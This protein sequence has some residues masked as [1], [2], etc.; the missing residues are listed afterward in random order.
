MLGVD[1]DMDVTL[2]LLFQ[3]TGAA[4]E[5]QSAS[6]FKLYANTPDNNGIELSVRRS[7]ATDLAPSTVS[8]DV[9]L[10]VGYQ[11]PQPADRPLVLDLAR[12]YLL[13]AT[14]SK[15]GASVVA[16]DVD[17]KTFG[18]VPVLTGGQ[19]AGARI[20][21]ANV[22]SAINGGANWN[23]N[24][25]AVLVF[26]KQLADND[27]LSL[28]NYLHDELRQ[29]DPDY[30]QM[31]SLVQAAA[32]ATGC[33]YDPPTCATCAPSVRDWSVGVVG[34]GS[35]ECLAAIDA[36]CAA[37][38]K[39]PRCGCWD[40]SS[41]HFGGASCQSYRTV[42]SGQAC[43]SGGS[44]GSG[45]SDGSTPAGDVV[46]S[47]LTPNNID[48][49]TKLITAVRGPPHASHASHDSASDDSDSDSDS[50]SDDGDHH[51]RRSCGAEKGS[52]PRP[53]PRKQHSQIQDYDEDVHSAPIDRPT[54]SM[55]NLW[56]FF[57]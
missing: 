52:C 1:G 55:S 5:R 43:G 13:I 57:G 40:A 29:F 31:Q 4:P 21:L 17:A 8:Y 50:D 10:Q 28:Y 34:Q 54:A 46:A 51:Q 6:L 14:K 9:F 25:L 53:R 42:F 27:V 44:G 45:S 36:F 12:R 39:H 19:V 32:Q 38:P 11:P 23:A 18:K 3:P 30:Q 49:V 48:A 26:P 7:L 37:N 41:P 2:A 22:E 20:R 16:V 15:T 24:L 56:G 33:P 35:A 47:I